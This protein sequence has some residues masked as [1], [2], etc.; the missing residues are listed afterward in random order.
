MRV[1]MEDYEP[2][3]GAA[4]EIEAGSMLY[5]GELRDRGDA[6]LWIKVEHALN[7]AALA[8]DRERWG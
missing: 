3:L 7:R 5:W 2:A 6:G 8:S 1:E 4:L